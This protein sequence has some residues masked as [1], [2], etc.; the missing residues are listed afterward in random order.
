MTPERRR[1]LLVLALAYLAGLAAALAAGAA[2]EGRHPLLVTGLADV[3]A[4]VAVFAFSWRVDNSS[5][6]DPYW[7]VAP[8]PI[9]GAWLWAGEPGCSAPRAALASG[10]V[11]AW[12]LRLT[13][14]CLARWRS[15]ADEDFRYREIRARTGAWYWPASLLSIHLLP[16]G[17]VFLGLV[18]LYPALTGPGRAL[19]WLDLAAAILTGGAILIEALA[20]AQLR[21]F[22]AARR[23]PG[24]VL[25]T[26][27]WASS[28]HPNYLGEVLFWWGLWLFGL[29]AD[30]TWW[31]TV[32]GPLAITALFTFVSVP[33]MDRRM[34]ARHP[35]WLSRRA[36]VP[37]LWPRPA[38][39]P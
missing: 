1:L 8:L 24:A 27:L 36:A 17:W 10:L 14:N 11:L 9:L 2:L 38:R 34:E 21:R 39:R 22:L 20:D 25:E 16:T 29:A 12:G 4:T 15:L 35:G 5:V 26:G 33:W 18:P 37:A 19:G 3:A 32:A 6:Y 30:P 13:W 7:S 31:W 28:R 23:E